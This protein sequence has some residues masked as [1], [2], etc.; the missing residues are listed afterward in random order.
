MPAPCRWG[1]G[2][3]RA[4]CR[5]A[6]RAGAHARRHGR[7]ARR[8]Q[9]RDQHHSGPLRAHARYPRRRRRDAR[10]RRGRRHGGDRPYRG[11]TG[12]QLQ[13]Y[14][15]AAD[16]RGAVLAAPAVALGRCRGARRRQA[17][18]SSERRRP[19]CHDVRRPHRRR[20]AVRALR[21]RR[22]QS[23]AARD[24]HR[25][26]CRY[27]G[28]RHA[29]CRASAGGNVMTPADVIAAFVDRDFPRETEFL[30]ELVKVPSDNPPGDCAAHAK[31]AR[32]LMERLGLAVEAHEVPRA[33]VEAAGMK[34]VPNLIIRHRFDDG[35]VI[36]LS[37]HGDVVPPGL[38]WRLDPYGAVIEDGA[39]GPVMYGR[40]VAVSKSDF[41]SYTWALLALKAAAAQGVK[42][43]GTLE[44]H[45]TYDEEAGGVVGP[46]WLLD[47]GLTKP[48]AAI[49][50]GF[51]YAVVS[52]H[53]GCLHLEVTVTGKQ[54]HAAMPEAGVDALEATNAILA[55]LYAHRATLARIRSGTAG[56]VSPTL[57]VGLIKGG[58]NT[59]VVPDQVV[60]RL[61]RRLIPEENPAE[62]EAQLREL[63]A[64]AAKQRPQV[65]V[66]ISRLLLAMP[67]T[68][69]PG[70]DRIVAAIQ[71]HARQVL[72][73][74]VPVTGV[75]L[76]TDARHYAAAGIPV[77]LYG[78]GPRS[79][80]EANA[81][82]AN[83][84]LRLNDLRA[85]TKIVAMA[86]GDLCGAG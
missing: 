25:R 77:V 34:S 6:L 51:S 86:V 75:P 50:A 2:R 72:G 47:Q 54:A 83:E 36:A 84:N 45:F 38:G 74:D 52:A 42:F 71:R 1:G 12:R 24:H 28:A 23:F 67:L 14:G 29:R 46:K 5:T 69:Q 60:F 16:R 56:I 61:D 37:A 68:P 26:G 55:V 31:R 65:K 66:A 11:K 85:A 18:P 48:D 79:I 3:A 21:K 44:L 15:S 82:N 80:L 4:L 8:P 62:V 53:N 27:R 7:T 57:N 78:A 35:P 39:H 70:A 13:E 59:N 10:C 19:R 64:A 76:Y 9:R 33:A 32:Q 63:I 22:R 73:V 20:H 49:A 17:A 40:G 41:A 43:D 81:H 58:I 30:A